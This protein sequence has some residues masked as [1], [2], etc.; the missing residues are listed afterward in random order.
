MYDPI[1]TQLS[2][3]YLKKLKLEAAHLSWGVLGGWAVFFHVKKEYEQAFGQPYLASRDIDIFV[4]AKDEKRFSEVI[5]KLD[6]RPS[7]YPFRYELIY[8]REEKRIVHS[9][10][11]KQQHIF[12]LVYIFLDI[13]SNKKTKDIG[14]WVFPFLQDVKLVEIEGFPALPI[15]ILLSMK[16][17]S[18]FE[19]EKLDKELKDG[20]DIYAL[21]HYGGTKIAKTV[22]IQHA[23]RKILERY[24]LQ[25]YIAEHVLLDSLK[26]NLVSANMKRFLNS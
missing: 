17:I 18:F 25:T 7:A 15:S 22:E 12:H 24:D 26:V 10:Q 6:F 9:E 21:L 4:H 14:S 20:C 5:K 11:A 3:E 19:R 23:A 16:I 13:F 1:E 2:Y 8:D